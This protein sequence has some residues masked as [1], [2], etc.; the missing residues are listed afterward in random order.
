[1]IKLD[2]L[3]LAKNHEERQNICLNELC[4]VNPHKFKAEHKGDDID[5]E[6]VSVTTEEINGKK[7]LKVI[8]KAWKNNVEIFVDNPLYYLNPPIW[9]PDGTFETIID[10]VT[11]KP[12]QI[13]NFKESPP[14]ALRMIVIDT[15]KVTALK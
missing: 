1:M 10:K 14:E 3:A 9:V 4:S 12:Q 8:A 6:I 15:L 13:S 5:V 7:L 2:K 11:K